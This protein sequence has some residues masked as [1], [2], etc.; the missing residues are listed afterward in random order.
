MNKLEGRKVRRSQIKVLKCHF[1]ISG[2]LVFP[3]YFSF[4]VFLS[5]KSYKRQKTVFWFMAQNTF[6][7][8]WSV[9]LKW[10]FF[11]FLK[12]SG[13]ENRLKNERERIVLLS[14]GT[15]I[16]IL[17]FLLPTKSVPSFL[18]QRTEQDYLD[19]CSEKNY[20]QQ[21]ERSRKLKSGDWE[22]NS[23][24]YSWQTQSLNQQF[25]IWV[26]PITEHE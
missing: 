2:C 24:L 13:I 1:K 12:N 16:M 22:P 20:E 15:W 19:H 11:L 25:L 10:T 23:I 17:P 9:I 4:S 8:V 18:I 7:F 21:T 14:E 5:G 3:L 26:W 6:L